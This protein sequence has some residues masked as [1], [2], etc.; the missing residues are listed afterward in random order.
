MP[1]IIYEKIN[2]V[3]ETIRHSISEE[4]ER[5]SSLLEIKQFQDQKHSKLDALS[6]NL[7]LIENII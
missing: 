2:S 3:Q 5:R 7:E 6:Q 1:T 4:L